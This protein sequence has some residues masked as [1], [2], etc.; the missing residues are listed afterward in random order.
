MQKNVEHTVKEVMAVVL[1]LDATSI[2]D[3]TAMDNT[4]GWDSANQINLVLALEEEF[5]VS[6]EVSEMEMMTNY[7]DIVSV[8]NAKL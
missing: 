7:I 6:F 1:N 4:P 5:N 2:D 3:G 8:L